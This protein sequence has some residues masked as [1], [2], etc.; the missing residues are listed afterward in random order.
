METLGVNPNI[1]FSLDLTRE[2]EIENPNS[3]EDSDLYLDP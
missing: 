2:V 1:L 3:Q